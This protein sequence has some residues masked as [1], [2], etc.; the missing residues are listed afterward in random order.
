[1]W[2][3]G[4][5]RRDKI[6]KKCSGSFSILPPTATWTGWGRAG[7]AVPFGALHG[8]E[9]YRSREVA[10]PSCTC[11]GKLHDGNRTNSSGQIALFSGEEG[12]EKSAAN[13]EEKSVVAVV[14]VFNASDI[15]FLYAI[16]FYSPTLGV[17]A[18]SRVAL[19]HHGVQTLLLHRTCEIAMLYC[20]IKNPASCLS[21]LNPSLRSKVWSDVSAQ[22]WSM[23]LLFTCV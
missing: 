3:F 7:G 2:A 5:R 12:E 23:R 8:V 20:Y 21:Y 22:R 18:T 13:A 14:V 17:L 10:F 4:A 16:S 11:N 6:N 1:M 15:C 9:S 19:H